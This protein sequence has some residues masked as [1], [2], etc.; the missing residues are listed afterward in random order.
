MPRPVDRRGAL[1]HIYNNTFLVTYLDNMYNVS[2]AS[3]MSACIRHHGLATCEVDEHGS[4]ISCIKE[5][6]R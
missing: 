2:I 4:G 1:V 3:D 6:G 5:E